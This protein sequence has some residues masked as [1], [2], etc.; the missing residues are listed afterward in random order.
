M[1]TGDQL[2]FSMVQ[3]PGS[4]VFGLRM[5]LLRDPVGREVLPDQ[6]TGV[7]YFEHCP[8]ALDRLRT[9]SSRLGMVDP[10][11]QS[12]LARQI[13]LNAGRTTWSAACACRF[14]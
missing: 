14:A 11:G 6:D 7:I 4:K 1:K 5:D 13:D 8:L 9:A 2:R 12:R 3:R 10:V